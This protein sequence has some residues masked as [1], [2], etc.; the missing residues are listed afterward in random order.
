[1][2]ELKTNAQSLKTHVTE[3]VN[4]YAQLAKAKATQGAS[5]AAGGAA[6]GLAAFVFGIFFLF[7]LFCGLAFWMG[8]LVDSRAGGFL[9][10]AGFFLLLIVVIFAMKNK[11]IVPA[12][13][14]AIISK[15]YE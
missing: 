15:V 6:V 8:S 2:E 10:V 14:N 13:R 7:F 4:T 5:N 12:I 1:M 11:V 3:Y 9:I